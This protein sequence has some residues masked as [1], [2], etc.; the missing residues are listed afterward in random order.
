[1]DK[2]L[3]GGAMICP[4]C[5]QKLPAERSTV[6][7]LRKRIPTLP[8]GAVFRAH[9]FA[10]EGRTKEEIANNLNYLF[11]TGELIR[12]SRGLYKRGSLL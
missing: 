3:S 4:H 8:Q 11:R 2:I 6:M 1:M 5:K 7:Y 12:V 9:H 10:C